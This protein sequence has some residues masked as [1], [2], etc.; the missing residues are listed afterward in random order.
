MLSDFIPCIL[1]LSVQGIR[2]LKNKGMLDAVRDTKH[3]LHVV[4]SYPGGREMSCVCLTADISSSF[5]AGRIKFTGY[6]YV[7]SFVRTKVYIYVYMDVLCSIPPS[8]DWHVIG[9]SH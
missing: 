5:L 9:F 8:A 6:V 2:F 4:C 1:L 3:V 7:F